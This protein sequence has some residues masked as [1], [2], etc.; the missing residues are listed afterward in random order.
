[1]SKHFSITLSKAEIYVMNTLSLKKIYFV[2]TCFVLNF[3]KQGQIK[4]R[5]RIP[6]RIGKGSG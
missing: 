3:Q 1:M 6:I 4:V 5:I 2:Q